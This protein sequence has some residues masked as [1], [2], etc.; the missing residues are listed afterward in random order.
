MHSLTHAMVRYLASP[1]APQAKS[2]QPTST[3]T[4]I[5]N[6]GTGTLP[7]AGFGAA[8]E[9]LM[10]WV[11]WVAVGA[12]VVGVLIVGA[13]MAVSHQRGRASEHMQGLLWV[14][15][16]CILIGTASSL[17]GVFAH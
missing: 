1:L 11:A 17:V 4:S 15:V 16:G 10:E 12:C 6:P 8:L 14:L 3:N 9:T 13:T 5:F 2:P 7:S